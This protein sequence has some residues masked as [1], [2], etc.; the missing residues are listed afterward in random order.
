MNTKNILLVGAGVVVGYLLFGYL[1]KS[2]DKAQETTDSTEPTVDQAKID[3]CNKEVADFMATAKFAQ[4][5]DLDKKKKE[6]FDACM[7]KKA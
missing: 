6:M 5:V 2:K 3:A 4:G 1:N 7:A